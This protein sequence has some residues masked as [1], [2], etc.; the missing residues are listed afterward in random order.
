M[1]LEHTLIEWLIIAVVV[2]VPATLAIII[3]RARLKYRAKMGNLVIRLRNKAVGVVMG[4]C[5]G[6]FATCSPEDDEHAMVAAFGGTGVGKTSALITPS[7]RAW[8]RNSKAFVIDVSGDIEKNVPDP[9]KLIFSPHDESTMPYSVFAAVDTAG[10]AAERQELLQAIS[11]ALIPSVS[12]EKSGESAY[13]INSAR[14]MLQACLIAYYGIGLDFIK[15]CQIVAGLSFAKLL[16]DLN[17]S[18]NDVARRLV[19]GFN[20]MNPLTVGGVKQQLDS[21]IMLF[22]TNPKLEKCI[23]RGGISPQTLETNSVYIVIQ[24]T[25]LELYAPLLRLISVQ[26]LSYLAGRENG[27]SPH[28]L[29]CLDE[30]ASLGKIDIIPALRKLRKKSARVLI[31]TQSLADLDLVYGAAERRAMMENFGYKVVLSASDRDSQNY[32]SDLAGERSVEKV[33]TTTNLAGDVSE[34]VTLQRERIIDP[35]AFAQ[36]DD[37]LILFHPRGV[38]KLKKNSYFKPWIF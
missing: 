6:F 7:L 12:D 26:T 23:R 8:S 18:G 36:L 29:V 13:F 20:D 28:I 25:K 27:A 3:I 10:D 22:A 2:G 37:S 19:A 33:T 14:D 5:F 11:Y 9:D 38:M 1:E 31:C 32:F 4:A 24:D 30:F 35:E 16:E 21:A 15:I 34:S 17:A